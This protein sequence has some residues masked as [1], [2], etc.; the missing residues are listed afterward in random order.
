MKYHVIIKNINDDSQ[1]QTVVNAY[2]SKEAHEKA[3]ALKSNATDV[4]RVYAILT[5]DNGDINTYALYRAS[6]QVATISAKKAMCNGGTDTQ[7]TIYNSLSVCN[8]KA[9][10]N[11]ENNGG[12]DYLLELISRM[13]HDS[14]EYVSCAYEGLLTGLCDKLSIDDCYH[15]AYIYINK[16]IMSQRSAT[17]HEI[18]TEYITDN[19]G[20]L[21]A[22][23]NYVAKI[24]NG[25]DRYIPCDS[26]IMD[27]ETAE[28]LGSVLREAI[29]ILNARQ[30]QI[31]KYI[32]LGYSQRAVAEKMKYKDVSSVAQ[33]LQAIRKKVFDYI[34]NNASEFLS[35]IDEMSVKTAKTD[36]HK[37][38]AK[39]MRIYRERKKAEKIKQ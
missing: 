8:Y 5:H 34:E 33:H 16:Y 11:T 28:L 13:D 29:A 22:I 36:R 4:I 10:I 37:N 20:E 27:S 30:K 14:Q 39:R 26:G 2:N 21:I 7:R 25:G 17:M 19:D 24:I 12:T 15:N 1:I 23:N 32:A 9:G 35:L 31:V 3:N 38:N 6:I 18:S